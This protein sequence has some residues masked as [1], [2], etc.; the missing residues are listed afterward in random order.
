MDTRYITSAAKAEQ[1]PR[2]E[3]AEI[4]FIGRSNTGKSTL[5]NA[6]MGRRSLARTG[7][8]PGQTKMINFF[9]YGKDH[10]FA[11]LPGYGYH[12][13]SYHQITKHWDSLV[14]TY[15]QRQNI[16]RIAFLLDIRR[17]LQPDDIGLLDQL[18]RNHNVVIVLTKSDK[19][20]RSAVQKAKNNLNKV[21]EDYRIQGTQTVVTSSLKKAGIEDLRRILIPDESPPATPGQ[22][23]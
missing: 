13:A 16:S 7:R 1:L 18:S 17:N 12:E 8:T 11:D 3:A 19:V 9:G 21:L 14:K 22:L 4:G 6:L 2:Y 5:L 20:N 23:H 10:I 15:L